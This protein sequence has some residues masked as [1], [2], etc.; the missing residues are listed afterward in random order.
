MRNWIS[1]QTKVQGGEGVEGQE[2][3]NSAF[4]HN[5]T[6]VRNVRKILDCSVLASDFVL[7]L[8]PTFV[9]SRAKFH[10]GCIS[11]TGN[12]TNDGGVLAMLQERAQ[13][14]TTHGVG[15]I[16]EMDK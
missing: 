9:Y 10:H 6:K 8:K 15:G 3:G 1:G 5:N 12:V 11:R 4:H 2:N 7:S 16:G 14:T 13:P